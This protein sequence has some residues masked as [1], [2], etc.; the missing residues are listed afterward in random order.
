MTSRSLECASAYALRMLRS[1]ERARSSIG[2]MSDSESVSDDVSDAS[3]RSGNASESLTLSPSSFFMTG[4]V[5]VNAPVWQ[6]MS[7]MSFLHAS[8]CA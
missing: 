4:V 6:V 5:H 1:S 2:S 8:A 3:V 7:C